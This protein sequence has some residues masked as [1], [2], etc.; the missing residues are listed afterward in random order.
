MI[1]LSKYEMFIAADISISMIISYNNP[2]D[3]PRLWRI[4]YFL[5]NTSHLKLLI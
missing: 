3:Y 5:N 2:F 1:W 4:L